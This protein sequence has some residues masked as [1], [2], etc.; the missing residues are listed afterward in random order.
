MEWWPRTS[1]ARLVF[2]MHCLGPRRPLDYRDN[3]RSLFCPSCDCRTC[4]CLS[5]EMKPGSTEQQNVLFLSFPKYPLSR[6]QGHQPACGFSRKH[7]N[8]REPRA[9]IGG[10]EVTCHTPGA[11]TSMFLQ[12]WPCPL[13]SN[14]LARPGK[15]IA[16]AQ[17]GEESQAMQILNE[18]PF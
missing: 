18:R 14:R 17:A 12:P 10:G 4:P 7:I 15:P 3:L 16:C 9:V 2:F 11:V 5:S 8:A 13:Q 6:G 1:R